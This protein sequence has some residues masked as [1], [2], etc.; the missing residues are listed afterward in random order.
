MAKS[1]KRG[2]IQYKSYL[3]VDKDPV[4]D[5]FRTARSDTKSSFQDIRDAGGP[6]VGTMRNWE[7]GGVKRPQF[8]TVA[9]ATKAMG[10]SIIDLS[11]G[12]PRIR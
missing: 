6:T 8:A 4:I 2:F 7:S 5:A 12:K 11:A 9:A 3:F 1:K 10:K